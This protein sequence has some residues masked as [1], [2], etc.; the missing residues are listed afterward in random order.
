MQ[1]PMKE[2]YT[3]Q[4]NYVPNVHTLFSCPILCVRVQEMTCNCQ[5]CSLPAQYSGIV[6]SFLNGSSPS[7]S[8]AAQHRRSRRQQEVTLVTNIIYDIVLLVK[9][10]NQRNA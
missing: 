10:I 4:S 3:W 8:G 6:P 5:R 1:S 7:E 9:R 2:D